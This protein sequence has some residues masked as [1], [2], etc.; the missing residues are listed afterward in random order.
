MSACRLWCSRP[1][2][3]WQHR[4]S[5]RTPT[6]TE[7]AS[8]QLVKSANRNKVE[9]NIKRNSKSKDHEAMDLDTRD[10]LIEGRLLVGNPARAL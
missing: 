6:G 3:K 2:D 7:L 10:L 4:L 9:S 5:S 1:T 8:I